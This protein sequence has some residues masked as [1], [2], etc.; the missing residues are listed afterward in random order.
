MIDVA[1]RT[2]GTLFGFSTK[3]VEEEPTYEPE[4]SE[5]SALP[6]GYFSNPANLTRGGMPELSTIGLVKP[7]VLDP[8][9]VFNRLSSLFGTHKQTS[10]Y[11]DFCCPNCGHEWGSTFSDLSPYKEALKVLEA[12]GDERVCC[13]HCGGEDFVCNFHEAS[14]IKIEYTRVPTPSDLATFRS[15]YDLAF[16]Q[17]HY[18]ESLFNYFFMSEEEA[19]EFLDYKRIDD[20][21]NQF[22]SLYYTL[23]TAEESEDEDDT[24]DPDGMGFD[25]DYGDE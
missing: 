1:A 22:F 10:Y 16:Y 13:S 14:G 4:S 6:V 11:L 17:V 9:V 19:D 3:K 20:H 8:Q 21:G 7:I 24:D 25:E 15:I 12:D 5:D 2:V 18:L 23:A